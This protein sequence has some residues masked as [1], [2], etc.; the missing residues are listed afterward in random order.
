MA[1]TGQTFKQR[2]QLKQSAGNL[3]PATLPF[4]ASKG[5][6]FIQAPHWVHLSLSI[7]IRKM[8]NFSAIHEIKPKG[9]MS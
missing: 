2:T 1:S 5:H 3:F 9:Q 6:T 7:R 4:A 8:L